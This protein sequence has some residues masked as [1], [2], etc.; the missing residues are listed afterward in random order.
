ML[1]PGQKKE[2]KPKRRDRHYSYE[3]DVDEAPRL[4]DDEPVEVEHEVP[5]ED[6]RPIENI[7]KEDK[8]EPPIFEE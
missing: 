4:I 2:I 7:D 3:E 5:V 6:R 8:P 1:G